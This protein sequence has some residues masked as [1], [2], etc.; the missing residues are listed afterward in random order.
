MKLERPWHPEFHGKRTNVRE[1]T[2]K[3]QKDG[4]YVEVL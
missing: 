4:L 3:L 1:S 2:G